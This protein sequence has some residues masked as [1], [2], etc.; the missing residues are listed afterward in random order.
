MKT[1]ILVDDHK[2]FR[3]SLKKLLVSEGIANVIGEAANGQEF[4]NLLQT[5]KPDIVLIDISM[6]VMGG[7]EAATKA[8]EINPD[9][10]LITL[11]SL[12][13]E[14]YYY[15]MIEA[16]VKGFVLKSSGITELLQ[17]IEE[18][19]NGGSWFSNELLRKVIVSIGKNNEKAN[20]IN[21]S[22]REL[23]VLKLICEG[24]TNDQIANELNLSADTIK[25]HRANIF[26]KT[27]VTNAAALVM[28]SIRNKLIEI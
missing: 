21:L 14:Q 12:G 10:K 4:L 22:D 18:V 17:A 7:G 23:K 25:W 6:P 15:S 13:N 16:G 19:A 26:T 9:M 28:F 5:L 1:L 8:L 27:E 3:E 2:M 24:F 20:T 11:S